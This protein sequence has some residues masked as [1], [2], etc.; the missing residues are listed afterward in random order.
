VIA[1]LS[2]VI[3]QKSQIITFE[4]RAKSNEVIGDRNS[5]H[6]VLTNL[7]DNASK[8]TNTKGQITVIS[9]VKNSNYTIHILDSGIGLSRKDL[10]RVFN[11]FYR[12]EL[13]GETQAQGTG[14]GLSIVRRL[15]AQMDG[16]VWAKSRGLGEGST[17]SFSL[18]LVK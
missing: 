15:V 13:G 5:I 18:P 10:T 2:Q 4:N 3:E 1:E 11:E 8:Y 9:E 6:Q 7:I 17:F 12:V 16:K 14:L